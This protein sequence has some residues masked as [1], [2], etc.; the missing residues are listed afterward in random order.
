VNLFLILVFC[1]G[2]HEAA[3]EILDNLEA[4]S[5]GLAM[6]ALRKIGLE[7]RRGNTDGL[8][9]MYT[10]YMDEAKERVVK[11][12]FCIKYARYLAKVKVV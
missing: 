10:K 1:L 9:A 5:P 12:F 8:D 6:V 11:S 4:D 7:R 3:H 2:N